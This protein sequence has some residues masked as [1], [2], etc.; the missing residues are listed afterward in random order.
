MN[1][2]NFKREPITT[3]QV[4]LLSTQFGVE[5][6]VSECTNQWVEDHN[7]ILVLSVIEEIFIEDDN[8]WR[9]L[10]MKQFILTQ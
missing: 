3:E 2:E 1:L 9:C 7:G 6:W 4:N 5:I 8:E 10:P